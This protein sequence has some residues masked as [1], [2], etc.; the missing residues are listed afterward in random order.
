MHKVNGLMEFTYMSDRMGFGHTWTLC[1]SILVPR[2]IS[3]ADLQHAANEIFRINDQLRVRFIESGE[4][5]EVF[6]EIKP[7]EERTFDTL[8]FQSKEELDDW[9]NE[10]VRVPLPLDVRRLGKKGLSRLYWLNKLQERVLLTVKPKDLMGFAT[11]AI[12]RARI[13]KS[14]AIKPEPCVCEMRLVQLPDSSGV[15]V[16]VHHIVSDA[17]SMV[18]MANQFLRILQ[19]ETPV[20][21]SFEEHL[22]SDEAYRESKAFKR[23]L[24]FFE[25]QLEL[26]P[27]EQ[28]PSDQ[29][30]RRKTITLEDEF[31]SAIWDY[32][33]AHSITPQTLFLAAMGIYM[34]C[35]RKIEKRVIS[36]VCLN[37]AGTRD[38]N[39]VGLFYTVPPIPIELDPNASFADALATI[40]AA[41]LAA[42]RH[43]RASYDA[44]N[45]RPNLFDVS[46]Q[47]AVLADPTAVC[48]QYYC[49]Y[50]N[51]CMLTVED[52]SRE[53]NFKL[54]FDANLQVM[55]DDRE[56]EELLA[57]VT[58]VVRT[59]IEDDAKP[60]SQL[61]A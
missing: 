51:G 12:S 24:A 11:S 15:I 25:K 50:F 54:H 22:A 53:G 3:D 5:K 6:Q 26:Y 2:H 28:L 17:W 13:R 19:G 37:R 16:K 49:N 9:G 29:I 39:T 32:C 42:M 23:D 55:P 34:R 47:N 36:S 52:R 56:I 48:T 57:Y 40:S 61:S 21:Y 33:S 1:A 18:L 45:P 8:H 44:S 38:K 14:L 30:A 43:Q 58:T 60:I 35:K 10:Y 31:S 20:A 4:T 41:N 7:F 59:G 46:Y 27:P